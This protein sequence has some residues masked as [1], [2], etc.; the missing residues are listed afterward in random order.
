MI[1]EEAEALAVV[2]GDRVPL[3]MKAVRTVRQIVLHMSR[4]WELWTYLVVRERI[5]MKR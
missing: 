5:T 4:R 1:W 2:S 3:T